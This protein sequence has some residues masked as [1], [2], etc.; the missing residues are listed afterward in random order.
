VKKLYDAGY[1][2]LTGGYDIKPCGPLNVIG[3]FGETC[4]HQFTTASFE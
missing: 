2:V 3:R 4:C 1:Q